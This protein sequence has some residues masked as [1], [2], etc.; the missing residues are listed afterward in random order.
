MKKG[1]KVLALGAMALAALCLTVS[2]SGKGVDKVKA[3]FIYV[4]PVGDLGWSNAHDVGRKAV[5]DKYKSW[6]ST[7]YIESVSEKDIVR[8]SQRLVKEKGCNIVFT[9]SF[10]YMDNTVE[11]AKKM[12]DVTFMHCSGYKNEKNL[13]TYFAELYQMYYLNG[14]MAG[15]LTKSNKV[16]YVGAFKVNEVI[17][18]IDAFALGV[19]AANPKATVSVRWINS[20]YDPQKATEAA[21]A[22]V[23]SGVDALAFTEDSPAVIQVAEKYSKTGKQ[24][25]AFSHYSPMMKYGPNSVVSGELV[26][27]GIMYDKI[28]NDFH[29]GTWSN[30]NLYW[31]AKEGAAFLGADEKTPVN[32]K[33]VGPLKAYKIKTADLG[34]IDAYSL[35]MKRYDQVKAGTFEPFAGPLSDD[36]GKVRFAAG[37]VPGP[38]DILAIDWWVDNVRE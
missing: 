32:P 31:R 33:F 10:E 34:E 22:L 1:I 38:D 2:A 30:Y 11:A 4:G 25:Y 3:G 16:G 20:W 28:L 35:A 12:S 17:R 6:L 9:T 37:K 13:G 21:E 15:A 23:A 27:W 36:K 19:K 7:E 14:L 5:A 8:T 29:N 26:D 24:V 18:H